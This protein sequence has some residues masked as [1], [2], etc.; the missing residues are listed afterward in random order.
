MILFK[1]SWWFLAG[2]VWLVIRGLQSCCCPTEKACRI[3]P[4]SGP[5][6]HVI[7]ATVSGFAGL[8]AFV[9]GTYPLTNNV[10]GIGPYEWQYFGPPMGGPWTN[11]FITL[12]CPNATP[13]GGFNFWVIGISGVGP[14][15]PSLN[16]IPTPPSV[17]GN[18]SPAPHITFTNFHDQL[19]SV[20]GTIVVGP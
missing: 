19:N 18:C 10:N 13:S 1:L 14:F 5:I 6:N 7:H 4:D 12:V 20:P 16:H 17:S 15:G 3:C 8:Y 9:N 11:I 2:L